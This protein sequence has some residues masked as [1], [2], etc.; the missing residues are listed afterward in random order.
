MGA[1][2]YESK[3]CML[4]SIALSKSTQ[5]GSKK[6]K[7]MVGYHNCPSVLLCQF[8]SM[9]QKDMVILVAAVLKPANLETDFEAQSPTSS[10]K[11]NGH[12]NEI[13]ILLPDFHRCSYEYCSDYCSGCCCVM[14]MAAG[15]G[16][17]RPRVACKRADFIMLFNWRRR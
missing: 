14:L 2:F 16:T 17:V 6:A 4:S 7:E 15:Q 10:P 12:I 13:I 8:M 11:R 1:G 3:K 9:I 5:K